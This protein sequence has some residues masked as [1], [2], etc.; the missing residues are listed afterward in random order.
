MGKNG[1]GF[2]VGKEAGRNHICNCDFPKILT[3]QPSQEMNNNKSIFAFSDSK[4]PHLGPKNP[5]VMFTP[6]GSPKRKLCNNKNQKDLIFINPSC[7]A[8]TQ[9]EESQ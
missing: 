8:D 7:L 4:L 2:L 3:K 1:M 9:N 6:V 5:C